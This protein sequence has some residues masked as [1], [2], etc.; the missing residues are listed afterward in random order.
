MTGYEMHSFPIFDGRSENVEFSFLQLY[1]KWAD[2]DDG[3]VED[4]MEI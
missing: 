3:S 2:D 1:F 4:E